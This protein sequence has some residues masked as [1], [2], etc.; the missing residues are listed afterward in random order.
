[1]S[2]K[3]HQPRVLVT[4]AAGFVGA[5]LCNALAGRGFMPR[6]VLRTDAG[7]PQADDVA[8]GE[9]GPG[10]LCDNA[11]R[12]MKTIVHLAAR[13]H[14]RH[15]TSPDAINQYRSVNV[16]GT[17]RLA[18]AAA[19]AGVRRLVFVSSVKV[20][21]ERTSGMPFAEDMPPAPQ[22]SYGLSKWEAEQAL[23]K[24]ADET[25]LQVV[26]LRPPLMYG[27]GVKGNFLDLLRAVDRG[28]P[29]PLRSINNQRSLL[30]VGD[31][32]N[33]IIACLEHPAAAGRTYLVV[34]R[35]A[36]STPDLIR[37]VAAALGKPARLLPC[38]P[39]LL[40][41]AA[42]LLGRSAVAS[43]L[44]DSLVADGSRIER[45][46]G[47]RPVSGLKAGLDA[48]EQWYYRSDE[49]K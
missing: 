36:V 22:D 39:A 17:E 15:E 27:P 35:D 16:A 24:V 46:L 18:R 33:A 31:L 43:R 47:W 45:D 44:I 25:G 40:R 26:V 34:D 41:A 49:R 30:Y 11:L 10:T 5:A 38:P 9:I 23:C 4:G 1:L 13:A 7:A 8:I 6:R 42:A 28:M 21:G 14:V 19:Q 29:L 20:H 3:D 37:S 2:D 48:T 32:A 12:G